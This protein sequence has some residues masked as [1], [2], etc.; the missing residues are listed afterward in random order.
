VPDGRGVIEGAFAVLGALEQAGDIGLSE[1]ARACALPKG[2]A[3]RLLTQLEAVGAVERQHG[4][5]QLGGRC[6]QLGRAW[7]PSTLLRA[8][9]ASPSRSLAAHT[10]ATIG[11][12]VR[13]GG[14]ALV[15]GTVA[16][17]ANELIAGLGLGPFEAGTTLPLPT[18]IAQVLAATGPDHG[19]PNGY[20]A[21]GWQRTRAA[22]T[23][24][25]VAFDRGEFNQELSCVAAPVRGR[26]G[27]TIASLCAVVASGR[28]LD[29]LAPLVRRAAATIA[30][31][32]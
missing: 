17:Q 24:S 6:Y 4:R 16:G 31:A 10:R 27:Q 11:L 7:R 29:E 28:P 18:A 2:T 32:L 14:R 3:H 13:C 21:P 30:S 22:V 9:A 23:Q 20:T 5:Y 8:A 12:A 19:I 15:V 1:L 25:G 26:D